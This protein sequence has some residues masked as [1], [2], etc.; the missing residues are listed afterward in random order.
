MAS[1]TVVRFSARWGRVVAGAGLVALA[2]AFAS[3]PVLNGTRAGATGNT[4][5]ING[6]DKLAQGLQDVYRLQLS[7]PA[8]SPN[9]LQVTLTS[10]TAVCVLAATDNSVGDGS[11]LV[12][13]IPAGQRSASFVAQTVDNATGT[14]T[15]SVS[16]TNPTG[17]STPSLDVTLVQGKLRIRDLAHHIGP[18]A[19]DDGFFVE[20]GVPTA[21][22]NGI[23]RVQARSKKAA[24]ALTVQVCSDRIDI[25]QIANVYG[26]VNPSGCQTNPIIAPFSRTVPGDFKFDPIAQNDTTDVHV[27][28]TATGF[29]S[30]SQIVDV[31]AL[32]VTI[33]GASE[34]GAGLQDDYSFTLSDTPASNFSVTVSS[35][36]TTQCVVGATEQSLGKDSFQEVV[37]AGDLRGDFVVQGVAVPADEDAVCTVRVDA[38]TFGVDTLDVHVKKPG[39]RL[40][41]LASTQGQ[42]G[43][44]DPFIAELGVPD[45]LG[46][47]L[48]L[49]Q[50][51]RRGSDPSV[52]STNCGGTQLAVTASSTRPDIGTIVNFAGQDVGGDGQET[53]YVPL[54]YTTTVPGDLAFDPILGSD[55]RTHVE[56]TASGFDT[57]D[58]GKRDVLVKAASLQITGSEDLGAALQDDYTIKLLD[59]AGHP[60]TVVTIYS[61]TTSYCKVA[62]SAFAVG[63]SSINVTVDAAHASAPFVIEAEEM[64]ADTTCHIYADATGY[65]PIDF[66]VNVVEG[67]IQIRQLNHQMPTTAGNDPFFV[68][69]GLPNDDGT[70]LDHPQRVRTG[71]TV[72]AT[73]CSSKPAVG[74]IV[75][76]QNVDVGNDGCESD[77][78]PGSY[79]NNVPGN[80][81]FDPLSTGTTL[82]E[83]SAPGFATMDRTG[84]VPVRVGSDAVILSTPNDVGAGLQAGAGVR[85]SKPA[86]SSGVTVTI[87]SL[88]PT[89]CVVAPDAATVGTPSV[90]LT[91]ASGDSDANFVV[92]GLEGIDQD[93]CTLQA[94]ATGYFDD[95]A[96]IGIKHCGFEIDGLDPTQ[97]TA[98]GSHSFL[99]LAGVPSRPGH[100]EAEQAVRIGGVPMP[101]NVCSSNTAVGG[102]GTAATACQSGTFQPGQS[103]LTFTFVVNPNNPTGGNTIVT[104]DG[105]C[106]PDQQPVKVAP[107][108]VRVPLNP[109]ALGKDLQGT[110]FI[111]VNN[112]N[113]VAAT[114]HSQTPL[115]CVV[116]SD[117]TIAGT[118]A[119]IGVTIAAGSSRGSFVVQALNVG[120][121]DL[122]VSGTGIPS[123]SIAIPVYYAR[124]R[125]SGLSPTM[126]FLAHND[127]FF[128]EI[129]PSDPNIPDVQTNSDNRQG[130]L[131]ALPRRA[132]L[133]PVEV[134]VCSLDSTA[135]VIRDASGGGVP[136]SPP[137]VQCQVTSI[138]A[139]SSQTPTLLFDPLA[140]KP[141]DVHAYAPNTDI[142]DTLFHVD[143]RPGALSLVAPDTIGVNLQDQ[144]TVAFRP[145]PPDNTTA[146]VTVSGPCGVWDTNQPPRNQAPVQQRTLPVPS[147]RSR[148]DFWIQS[149]AAG[150]C[151]IS[152]YSNVSS[153]GSDTADI[154]MSDPAVQIR[155][156]PSKV[157]TASSPP[158]FSVDL[159]VATASNS[160]LRLF[161]Q[162]R[163]ENDT[164]PL[165]VHDD[166]NNS[167]GIPL[168]VCSS[169]PTVGK[170]IVANTPYTCAAGVVQ[171]LTTTLSIFSFQPL[172]PP[173]TNVYV[174]ETG[175]PLQPTAAA[176]VPV[177]VVTDTIGLVDTHPL[178]NGLQDDYQVVLSR[179]ASST[180]TV[181]LT[182]LYPAI[183][184]VASSQ[185]GPFGATAQVTIAKGRART[186]FAVQGLMTGDCV[187]HATINLSGYTSVDGTIPIVQPALRI[188]RLDSSQ[189]VGAADD[190]FNV[191]I[192]APL[193]NVILDSNPQL[194]DVQ[195]VRLGAIQITVTVCSSDAAAGVIVPENPATHCYDFTI[196]QGTSKTADNAVKFHPVGTDPNTTVTATSAGVIGAAVDVVVKN[197]VSTINDDP[198]G[199]GLEDQYW[200]SLSRSS[201]V[202]IAFT[203]TTNSPGVCKLAAGPTGAGQN[204]IPITIPK[205]HKRVGFYVLA[206]E[207]PP[208]TCELVATTTASGVTGAY[209]LIPVVQPGLH[210]AGL[211]SSR[212][213]QSPNDPFS[214]QSGVL[215]SHYNMANTQKAR[216]D[217]P[218]I[219]LSVCSSNAAVGIIAGENPTTH[220]L[221]IYI[222]AGTD[223]TAANALQ[224]DAIA[225]GT[226]SVSATSPNFIQDNQD[227]SVSDVIANF[228]DD[229]VGAGLEAQRALYMNHTLASS[230]AFTVT[231][232]TPNTC[233]VAV[234]PTDAGQNSIPLTIPANH[235]RV[236]FY[237]LGI[238]S[239]DCHLVGTTAVSGIGTAD[240][241]ISIQVPLLHISGLP[242]SRS[243]Q[244]SDVSFKVQTG[245]PSSRMT[246]AD[247]QVVRVGAGQLAVTVCSSDAGIGIIVGENTTTHC[248][249]PVYIAEG[250]SETAQDALKFHVTGGSGTTTITASASN[251]FPDNHDVTVSAVVSNIDDDPVGAGLQ[252]Q[253]VLSVSSTL[254]A[255]ANF[256]ITSNTP[257]LCK[258]AV[259]ATDTGTTPITVTLPK[260]RTRAYFYV[261]GME[262]NIGDC[263]LGLTTDASGV[264]TGT[265]HIPIVQAGV[266]I[267]D[268]AS[269]YKT[270]SADA[271][272]H[273]QVGVPN[274]TLSTLSDTQLARCGGPGIDLYVCNYIPPLP[275]PEIGMVI[276]EASNGCKPVHLD[277]CKSQ[278]NDNDLKFHPGTLG[279]TT[280]VTATGTDLISTDAAS[281]DV[282]ISQATIT[283]SGGNVDAVGA[284]LE[285]TFT[286][287]INPSAGTAGVPITLTSL[288]PS[289]CIVS[290]NEA[291]AG[292]TS[293]YSFTIAS[294]HSFAHF[295]IQALENV[296]GDCHIQATSTNTTYSGDD[297][298]VQVRQPAL[299]IRNLDPTTTI[300]SGDD[301]FY[302]DTGV[303]KDN[304]SDLRLIQ[305]VRP[306]GPGLT[307][308]ACSS[309]PV[310]VAGTILGGSGT[311]PSCLSVP[312][313]VGSSATADNALKF[314][315]G[316]YQGNT[317]VYASATNFIATDAGS[318]D[319]VVAGV[320]LSIVDTGQH[321]VGAGLMDSFTVKSSTSVGSDTVVTITSLT[322]G[323]CLVAPNET[324][325]AGTQKPV[326]ITANHSSQTFT[327]HGLESVSGQ[328][329]L[330]AQAS[331]FTDGYGSFDIVQAAL[332]ISALGGTKSA[333]S[334]DDPFYVNT[335]IPK[336]D[337]ST[338]QG[339]TQKVRYGS[340]GLV[341]TACAYDPNIGLIL[342]TSGAAQCGSATIP[343]GSDNTT[344]TG[345][346][347]R[348]AGNGT[349][350]VDA[351]A[352]NL[353]TTDAG[354]VDVTVSGF[355]MSMINN[356][357]STIGAG[358]QQG[359]FIIRRVGST[360]VAKTVTVSS[361]ST[362]VCQVS[363][364]DSIAGANSISVTIPVGTTDSP[365]F[366]VQGVN[367]VASLCQLRVSDPY[368]TG[369]ASD[370]YLT[371]VLP[372]LR[373]RGVGASIPNN[374]PNVTF[375]VDIG[376]PTS[377]NA[378]ITPQPVK[379][380]GSFSVTVTNSNGAAAALLYNS[381]SYPTQVTGVTIPGG[382]S[383][384]SAT[385][386]FDPI[387]NGSTTVRVQP[388][389]FLTVPITTDTQTVTITDPPTC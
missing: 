243:T 183:C 334:T 324:S 280:T 262:H 20:A 226:T 267:T 177:T 185:A 215:N 119:D 357:G 297:I 32:T 105:G 106:S 388:L 244:S 209:Q 161:Q 154:T 345:L 42:Y 353:I 364:S 137:P 265:A 264:D 77:A 79:S 162:V 327:I 381:T 68:E 158:T 229:P 125:I 102:I 38:G 286:V 4:I 86:G 58:A 355:S 309:N 219:P 75:N 71:S 94:T 163:P 224:F 52:C 278:T 109:P 376:I 46:R 129:G 208:G 274:R 338:L 194:A 282:S 288:T 115:I 285:D 101:V 234:G 44:T 184:T 30:D 63:Q 281:K 306:G 298:V 159:G 299:R 164:Y 73:V 53:A 76:Y 246:L 375:Y 111:T 315:P 255:D 256:T 348:V 305:V 332:S 142:D 228:T 188:I 296:S 169:V 97:G 325:A 19:K 258:V 55:T 326:T 27:T 21:T 145:A 356:G 277:Q 207:V 51:L 336:A 291:T 49:V 221:P 171:Q 133:S 180:G 78:I 176:T 152:V 18:F 254:A 307:V 363:P 151:S 22:G 377:G 239:G 389:L 141:V 372:G 261:H 167:H 247:V 140:A 260:G 335:G 186:G 192:G 113:G 190:A 84:R 385:L 108:V 153:F 387:A 128:V 57:T 266:R 168:Q 302:I 132:G 330:R 99:V 273:V 35:L 25:G 231:S 43:P 195:N 107:T 271:A 146:T 90:I 250:A 70:Q 295:A 347:F 48:R 227:V 284:G 178:G 173:T 237:V 233:T 127:S 301:P 197:L 343:A 210:I 11:P 354:S 64:Q 218:G 362:G 82:V 300:A 317:T 74:T 367:G 103:R 160:K 136:A 155:N 61:L 318:V 201:N 89:K 2:L 150:T 365:A 304:L 139:L 292:T 123:I 117:P 26:D 340:A 47:D 351:S 368:Y 143:L 24:S 202:D 135:A 230:T 214:V 384:N 191:E 341:V 232:N 211:A 198:L 360:A 14:C 36:D 157:S 283:L 13:L 134:D 12:I 116:S 257:D 182:S 314:H 270:A 40:R 263:Q 303:A 56:V 199:A 369:P 67:G 371:T 308:T 96:D 370:L 268:L 352:P 311:Q 200:L 275:S 193:Q 62:Y 138:V 112:N 65:A 33:R 118:S 172:A 147:G 205:N 93:T 54:T 313:A 91:I 196:A 80:L 235:S 6:S 28:A 290:P 121:C 333:T 88:T 358:L 81:K 50:A 287:N 100:L 316:P 328:C 175:V 342:T 253:H 174:A 359:T 241:H 223:E 29:S 104:A 242:S 31:R 339:V 293:P 110:Y 206:Q 222:V 5:S 380:G 337:L 373:L 189:A 39:L 319:V 240:A 8:P 346:K 72:L 361:V 9:G 245:T 17:W 69:V 120:E 212:T 7:D 217:G 331:T 170:I 85:L 60:D 252:D 98:S 323:V 378:D 248:K 216:R 289:L 203:I 34:V 204:S 382:S 329:K 37:E 1:S 149:F 165:P 59:A 181:T 321:Q 87:V 122:T 251:F 45:P 220:C 66:Y 322:P 225:A 276:G 148:V 236:N 124:L 23:R 10:N 3:L 95:Q 320:A 312:I 279:G 131:T 272:F 92:A 269:S 83:A 130:I 374:Y 213:S 379:A 41:G 16:T 383:S 126:S 349:T 259:N 156:L 366:W 350:T 386:Q 238:A 187:I 294:R 15:V 179:A 114:V 310:T 166:I 249:G 344:S 144:V